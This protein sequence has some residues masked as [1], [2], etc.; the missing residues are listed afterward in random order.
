M[1]LWQMHTDPHCLFCS[2]LESTHHLFSDCPFFDLIRRSCPIKFCSD[3]ATCQDGQI[4]AASIDRK[5]HL[6]T[7][8]Y[9]TVA[10]YLTWKERNFRAHHPGSTHATHSIIVNLKTIA[11][12]KLFTCRTFR[13]WVWDDPTLIC[14]LY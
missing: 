3:W 2:N 8:L 14:L 5:L 12:E 1:I 10:V 4:F 7:S 9:L 13:K 11:R 6:I